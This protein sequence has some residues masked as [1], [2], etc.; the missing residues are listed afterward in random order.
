MVIQQ[1]FAESYGRTLSDA[2]EVDK[3]KRRFN[4]ALKQDIHKEEKRFLDLK[5]Q[6]RI[7]EQT[8]DRIL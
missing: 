3:N 7:K 2:K 4:E 5:E 8:E 1:D 6:I